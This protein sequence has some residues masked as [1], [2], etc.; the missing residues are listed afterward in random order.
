ML[1]EWT[2]TSQVA[3]CLHNSVGE[4]V[5]L[6]AGPCAWNSLPADLRE[7]SNTKTLKQLKTLVLFVFVDFILISLFLGNF[8]LII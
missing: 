2:V 8:I 6:F 5:F 4:R 3:V 7:R 1:C